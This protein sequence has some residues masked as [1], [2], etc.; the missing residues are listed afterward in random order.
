MLR[1]LPE[2]DRRCSFSSLVAGA[3]RSGATLDPVL[4]DA[5]AGDEGPSGPSLPAEGGDEDAAIG[6][7][8]LDPFAGLAGAS[9]GTAVHEALEIA[10]TRPRDTPFEP[11]ARDALAAGLRDR[12]LQADP[13]V[14]DGLLR[15]SSV[16]IMSGL[17]IRDLERGDVATELRFSLPVADGVD[18]AAIGDVLADGDAA[19]PFSAWSR[20]MATSA[21]PQPLAQTL[22][23]SIDLVTTFG[24]ASS[25][26]V[27]DYKTNLCAPDAG[28]Y[29]Q[30]GMVAKMQEA[31]YP[32]QAALYL[33]ALHRYLRWRVDGYDPDVHLGGS[34]YLF[35][36]GM[37]HGSD[38]GICPWRLPGGTV[39][40]L[41]D[42]LAG[43]R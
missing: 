32:L 18:L 43:V 17:A 39:A 2:R 14:I 24:S 37:R 26:W 29:S 42:T 16:P 5:G 15:V 13:A 20:R 10:M 1:A 21:S 22:V 6:S 8:A 35:L 33:V 4:G 23:G 28:G 12:A 34:L 19:G 41:S 7:T 11:V 31:D 27:I 40:T 30:P 9:F 38:D 36:R 25:Y 3:S